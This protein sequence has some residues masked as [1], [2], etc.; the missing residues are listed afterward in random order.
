MQVSPH[1]FPLR[2]TLQHPARSLAQPVKA[3]ALPP[4]SVNTPATVARATAILA[5]R[6]A[7]SV[8]R[9]GAG[10]DSASH[11]VPDL[12]SILVPNQ[13]EAED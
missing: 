6:N 10:Y 7:A 1:A 9:L 4:P 13:A 3:T 5:S 8:L 12:L 11:A 2:Q